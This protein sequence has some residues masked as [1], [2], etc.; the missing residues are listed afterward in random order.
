[1]F[2]FEIVILL[3]DNSTAQKIIKSADDFFSGLNIPQESSDLEESD[4]DADPD[5]KIKIKLQPKLSF[6]QNQDVKTSFDEP[7]KQVFWVIFD[8]KSV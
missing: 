3:E 2:E 6:H 4:S 5:E 1:M 7:T 8:C